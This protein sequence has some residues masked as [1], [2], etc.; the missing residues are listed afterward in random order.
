M[1]N[2]IVEFSVGSFQCAAISDGTFAYD[3]PARVFAVNAP[4]DLL[5]A[6][7]QSEGIDLDALARTCKHLC[8]PADPHRSATGVGRYWRRR[9]G[10]HDRSSAPEP[11]LPGH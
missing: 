1:T 5:A 9:P 3:H 7:L 2:E 4:H 11:A 8:S 6:A 10:A